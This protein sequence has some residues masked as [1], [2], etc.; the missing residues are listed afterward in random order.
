MALSFDP[1]NFLKLRKLEEEDVLRGRIPLKA[2]TT[3]A[4]G[5]RVENGHIVEPGDTVFGFIGL[6]LYSPLMGAAAYWLV[7]ALF[8]CASSE[9]NRPTLAGYILAPGV[10]YVAGR[11][12]H[13]VRNHMKLRA[14]AATVEIVI[15]MAIAEM[16]LL[17][18]DD[19]FARIVAFIE[20]VRMIAEGIHLF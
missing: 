19:H 2:A 10:A 9:Y 14:Y 4:E 12:L 17:G 13:W 1:E 3:F 6:A 7:R 15:G 11:T 18:H 8:N 20:G 16:L 5:S